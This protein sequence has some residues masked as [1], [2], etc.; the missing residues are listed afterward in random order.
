MNEERIRSNNS[1]ISRTEYLNAEKSIIAKFQELKKYPRI[2]FEDAIQ[3]SKS[4]ND[5]RRVD[6]PIMTTIGGISPI[7]EMK[8]YHSRIMGLITYKRTDRQ[9]DRSGNL[10]PWREK[11]VR[12]DE[13][14]DSSPHLGAAFGSYQPWLLLH[15]STTLSAV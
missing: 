7:H 2:L 10:Y 6:N 8:N 5:P 11:G 3:K 9:T 15:S 4:K 14:G 13:S 1:R 12:E